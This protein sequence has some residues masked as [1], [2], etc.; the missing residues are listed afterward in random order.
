MLIRI[1]IG[2][3]LDNDDS[4]FVLVWLLAFR[5][6]AGIGSSIYDAWT[7]G[8]DITESPMCVDQTTSPCSAH[9]RNF[10]IWNQWTTL[11]IKKVSKGEVVL[12]FC[13][14]LYIPLNDLVFL[15]QGHDVVTIAW[16]KPATPQSKVKHSTATALS[17]GK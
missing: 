16:L 2:W 9:Y 6:M 5:G 14:I 7:S 11:G 15:A 3:L 1:S 13:L 8:I 4:I 12:C 17:K 10:T